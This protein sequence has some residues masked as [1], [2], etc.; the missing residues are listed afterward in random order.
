MPCDS[1]DVHVA[2]E[3]GVTEIIVDARTGQGSIADA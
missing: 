1:F 2:G 3:K